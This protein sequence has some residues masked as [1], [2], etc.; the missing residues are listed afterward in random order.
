[1]SVEI[2]DLVRAFLICF[3]RKGIIVFSN[4]TS[5]QISLYLML[6]NRGRCVIRVPALMTSSELNSTGNSARLFRHRFR[7]LGRA[8]PISSSSS[9][10]EGGLNGP[11]MLDVCLPIGE[12][13]EG[14]CVVLLNVC[15]KRF[16]LWALV[17]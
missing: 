3:Q 10:S 12:N 7:S 14:G 2:V 11:A 13:A 15:T 1:M 9:T 16:S 6:C 8:G 17:D 5:I 4:P